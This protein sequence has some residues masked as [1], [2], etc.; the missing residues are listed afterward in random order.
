VQQS[1]NWAGAALIADSDSATYTSVTGTFTVPSPSAPEDGGEGQ[2]SAAAWVGIDGNTC[3]SAILQTGVDFTTSDDGSTTYDAWYEW[4]PDDSYD[5][6][7][8]QFSAGDSVTV[9]VN[10]TSSTSGTAVIENNTNGQK[11]S[12]S[13]TSTSPLCQTNVE[14]IVEDFDEGGSPVPL[15]DFGTVTFTGAQAATEQGDSVGPAGATIIDMET[16]GGG[17]ATAEADS[18][19]VT[20]TY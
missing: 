12:K 8:I 6:T 9:T 18:S 1:S 13:L 11:V 15:V 20:V 5:F 16:Q 14:W 2:Y 4:F 7:G 19:S 10:A 17:G 3:T